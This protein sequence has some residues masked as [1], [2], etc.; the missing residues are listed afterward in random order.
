MAGPTLS[1]T[2]GTVGLP[3][4]VKEAGKRVDF[5]P[6][7]FTLAVETKGYR[8]AWTQA[9]FCPCQ[10]NNAQTEQP[11]PNC[12]L[13]KGKG[14]LM[15]RPVVS[16]VDD[17]IIGDLDALQTKIIADNKASVIMGIMSSLV[18]NEHPYMAA[19]RRVE[20]SANLTVRADNKLGYWDRVVNL[21]AL[22]VY[23]QIIETDGQ[24]TLEFTYPP[25]KMNLLRSATQVYE[26]GDVSDPKDFI[27]NAGVLTWTTPPAAGV[28]LAAHYLCHPTW[29]VIEHPHTT[30][31]T[32][33]KYKT[34]SP[35]GD[36]IP[37][38]VQALVRYEFLPS[39]A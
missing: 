8:I 19:R 35:V 32:P 28:R 29:R 2:P 22:I 16:E 30:R 26:Q 25:A 20:G 14:W 15:F 21:D 23:S 4:G 37:L 31:V 36:P 33:V 3:E 38:P 11:D 10:P 39:E 24:A 1:L 9:C 7:D 12:D 27:I 34:T 13:C 18:G 17:R 6:D 5:R